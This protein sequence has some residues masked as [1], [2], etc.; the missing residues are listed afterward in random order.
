[1][2]VSGSHPKKS[3][4]GGRPDGM[5]T[6]GILDAICSDGMAAEE[7]WMRYVRMECWW[8]RISGCR[9]TS[10]WNGDGRNFRI[11]GMFGWNGGGRNSR[12]N[13]SGWNGGGGIPDAICPGGMNVV[14]SS[15][16]DRYGL[17]GYGG[18]GEWF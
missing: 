7:F 9:G 6:G 11:R 3:G 16:K 13:V 4:C 10:R 5:A 18:L 17:H 1:M 2:C 14:R 8:R 12:C 15:M